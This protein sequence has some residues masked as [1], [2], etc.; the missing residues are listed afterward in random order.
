MKN[1][2]LWINVVQSIV[3]I[4]VSAIIW[5]RK[6]DGAGISQNTSSKWISWIIWIILWAVILVIEGII[7]LIQKRNN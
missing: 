2:W 4:I 7:Y 3:F 5:L 6:Y 1:K